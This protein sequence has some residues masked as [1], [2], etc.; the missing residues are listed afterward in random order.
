M[1]IT[2]TGIIAVIMQPWYIL[3]RT[4]FLAHNFAVAADNELTTFK[5]DENCIIKN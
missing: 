3:L 4:V 2:D 5:S 1:I